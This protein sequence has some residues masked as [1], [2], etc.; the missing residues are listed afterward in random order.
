M[1]TLLVV[2]KYKEDIEWTKKIKHDVLIYDKSETPTPLSIA[3]PNIGREAET[4]L[5]YIIS[6][7]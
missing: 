3:R 6:K 1:K 4:L 7:Y 2:S 5:Y